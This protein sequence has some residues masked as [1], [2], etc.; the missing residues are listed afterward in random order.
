MAP[1]QNTHTQ[2]WC[3]RPLNLSLVN[4]NPQPWK[5]CLLLTGHGVNPQLSRKTQLTWLA[6]RKISKQ[7]GRCSLYPYIQ[8][9]GWCG[10]EDEQG[11]CVCVC[12]C[13]CV[14][15]PLSLPHTHI[16]FH[17]SFYSP[18]C[19]P[20]HWLASNQDYFFFSRPPRR[21]G[22]FSWEACQL[23]RFW[24]FP[25]LYISSASHNLSS[26][27]LPSESLG[28]TPLSSHL[29]SVFHLPGSHHRATPL[30]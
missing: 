16:T 8:G 21:H 20:L 4:V 3:S 10:W 26:A 27:L 5:H 24:S 25:L 1:P 30:P 7:F 11:V 9:S 29:I 22:N 14:N 18:S 28:P 6:P 13:V 2:V 23:L 17:L 19:T 12:P 15:L